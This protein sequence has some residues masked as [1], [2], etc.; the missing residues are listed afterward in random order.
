[1]LLVAREG[2]CAVANPKLR[3]AINGLGRTGRQTVR[4][5]WDRHRDDFDLVA[6]NGRSDAAMHAHL[7]KYDSDYGRFPAD[8]ESGADSLSI[9]GRE[10]RVFRQDDPSQIDWPSVNVDVVIEA[11][12][13][14]D[15][16]EAASQH[17]R[18]SVLSLIH[19]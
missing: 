2:V 1:M 16:R 7:L 14:F 4:A 5:W 8:I 19:I 18:G 13:E 10:V 9:G 3:V 15:Y 11:T 17:L 12:G 6:V